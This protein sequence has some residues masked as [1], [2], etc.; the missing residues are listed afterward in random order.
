[1]TGDDSPSAGRLDLIITLI[2]AL[3]AVGTA[4]AG[5]ESTK[6]SGQQ[7]DSYARAG[8]FRTESTSRATQAGQEK[9]V[10]LI[11]FTQWIGA[12]NQELVADPQAYANGYT[13]KPDR[14]SGFLYRRF[15]PE[16][17]PAIDAWIA[18]RPLVNPNAPPT[19]FAMP[20]YVIASD[21]ES[22]RLAQQADD[23]SIEAQDANELSDNYVLTAVFFAL[24]LFFA[25]FASRVRRRQSQMILLGLAGGALVLAIGALAT[26][27][28][29][30]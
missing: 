6:W 9:I 20:Q 22:D 4:W 11:A 1:M 29:L 17:R 3:A 30:L 27:P 8:A 23:A 2:M 24:V 12:V 10:D 26:F 16:F 25:G 19:P 28:V 13:P 14:L 15:R 18:T 21:A 7:A 5:F